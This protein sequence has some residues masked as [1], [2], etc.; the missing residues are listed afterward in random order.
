M[1]CAAEKMLEIE[2]NSTLWSY[3]TKEA[4]FVEARF[5]KTTDEITNRQ[6][7]IFS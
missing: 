7:S 6:P 4:T 5:S 3:G 1:W 2:F